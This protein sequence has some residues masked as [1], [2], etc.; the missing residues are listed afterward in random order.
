[1]GNNKLRTIKLTLAYDGTPFLG[2]QRQARGPT[3]QG[4]MEKALSKL[5]AH[6]ISL[7]ASGRTD[8]GVHA[9]GQVASFTTVSPRTEAQLIKGTNALLPP[10]IAVL[11]AEV[12]PDSFNARFDAKAKTYTYDFLLSQ[13]RDPLLIF[14]AWHVGPGLDW[15]IASEASQRL[16]G[17]KDFKSFQSAGT[18]LKSTIRRVLKIKFNQPRKELLQMIITGSGFLR[19]MVRTIAGTL[20]LCARGR[21]SPDEFSTVLEKKDR[22]QAGPVAPPQGLSLEKVYYEAPFGLDLE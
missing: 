6:P 17:L 1:M 22:S 20:W 15:T 3:I 4:L 2:W 9:R 18:E 13:I 21:L 7:Q 10:T 8:A 12:A 5:C 16:I 11:S 19:H 14:R